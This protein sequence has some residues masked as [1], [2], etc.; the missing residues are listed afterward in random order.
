MERVNEFAFYD[1][2]VRIHPLVGLSRRE[3]Y[4]KCWFTL[5][6]A[7]SALQ[8]VVSLRPLTVCLSAVNE[9]ADAIN[10][11]VPDDFD[12]AISKIPAQTTP[13]LGEQNPQEPPEPEKPLASY[14]IHRVKE[15]ATKFETVLS[16]E[17]QTLDTYFVSQKG[18]YK[19]SDLIERAEIVFPPSVREKL[20]QSAI[21][22]IKQAGR[23]LALDSPTASGFHILRAVESVMALYY[24]SVLGKMMPTRMRNWG[25]YIKKLRGSGKADNKVTDF[26]DHVRENYRNP[27]QHPEVMLSSDEAEVLFSI[28]LSVIRLMT[29]VL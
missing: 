7:R 24:K 4:S 27:V 23:C 2:A 8:E 28:S 18:S 22:D 14:L 13:L 10:N 29:A 26:L 15:A 19:M 11:I 5:F 6:Q 25:I 9:L 21:S 1:L 16:A 12:E 20:P 3:F 17:V